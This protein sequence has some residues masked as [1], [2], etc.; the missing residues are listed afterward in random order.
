M[1]KVIVTVGPALFGN[2]S[3]RG[4]DQENYIYRINGAHGSVAGIEATIDRIRDMLPHAE[5]MLDLPGNKV[6]TA[7]LPQPIRLEKDRRFNLSGDQLTYTQ[8]YRHLAAGDTVL[9]CDSTV[10]LIVEAVDMER[11]VI[12]FRSTCDGEIP[13]NKG[14]HVRGISEG[15]P[16]LFDKDREL[17]RLANRSGIAYLGLSFVRNARDIE[18][19]Q[20]QASPE[21]KLV[22]KVETRAAVDNLAEIL[23]AV[24]YI[25]I[26]RGDLSADVGI[27]K[28]PHYQKFIIEKAH[29]Y[30]RKVF[31]STQFLRNMV[32]NPV[33]SIAEI[34]DMYNTVKMGIYGIQ[35]S[36]ETSI[37]KYPKECLDMIR[38]VLQEMDSEVLV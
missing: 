12:A 2:G 16:F 28:I 32:E 11:G 1:K 3:L 22:S 24:E 8:F 4:I 36:E 20:S 19:A 30:N 34:V 25:L 33:P 10:T 5:I 23:R 21:I 17:I 27:E 14:F 29:F 6:R 13:A 15:L 31:L 18:E 37:G 35:L 26:D 7:N 38:K 9:A